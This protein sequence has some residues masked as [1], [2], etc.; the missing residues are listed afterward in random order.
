LTPW[1]FECPSQVL[2]HAVAHWYQTYRNVI[3]GLCGKSQRKK[4]TDKGR[5]LLTAA[6]F[7][8]KDNAD[9]Q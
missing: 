9:G 7:E 1:L 8:F 5:V 3:T 4:K 6:L 2:R